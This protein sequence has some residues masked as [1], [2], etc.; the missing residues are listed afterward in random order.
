[1]SPL[2]GRN[3]SAFLSGLPTAAGSHACTH[4]AAGMLA[5]VRDRA[6]AHWPVDAWR[7]R[8]D[9]LLSSPCNQT[10]RNDPDDQAVLH[11]PRAH[12]AKRTSAPRLHR[13]T[14]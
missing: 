14:S 10:V 1:M 12:R 8:L 6:A 3:I 5:A 2:T 7:E 9:S 13:S 11:A 4:A